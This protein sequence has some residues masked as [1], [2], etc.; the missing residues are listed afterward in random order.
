[1]NAIIKIPKMNDRGRERLP[2]IYTS[3][4]LMDVVMAV[5]S[6]FAAWFTLKD[7]EDVLKFVLTPWLASD[8]VLDEAPNVIARGEIRPEEMVEIQETANRLLKALGPEGRA[9]LEMKLA[10]I[11]DDE[12]ARQLGVSRPT[13][14]H[15][16]GRVLGLIR[17]ELE[18]STSSA[19]DLAMRYVAARLQPGPKA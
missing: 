8:L 11:P 6:S 4:H 14:A 17:R 9:I 2:A 15:R 7:L 10:G 1:V 12:V 3:E 16:K 5:A 13:A 18:G 19:Q